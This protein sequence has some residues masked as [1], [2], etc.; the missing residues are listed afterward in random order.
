MKRIDSSASSF[1]MY[2]GGIT[3]SSTE[4][5]RI[6]VTSTN[7]IVHAGYNPNN[8]NNDVALIRISPVSFNNRI[9]PIRLPTAGTSVGAGVSVRVSGWGRTSDGK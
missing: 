7:A 2:L 8:L 4:T 1:T 3:L 6:T 5:G 9:Q